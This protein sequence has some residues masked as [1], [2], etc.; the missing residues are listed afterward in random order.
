MESTMTRKHRGGG[1]LCVLDGSRAKTED[2]KDAT[3]HERRLDV[4]NATVFVGLR[5]IVHDAAIER[6][7][8]QG[9]VTIEV[10]KQSE[11]AAAAAV[12]RCLMPIKLRGAELKAMRRIMKLTLAELAKKL[13]ERTA[14]ETVSRWE[15]EAQPMGGYAEKL[16]R[17]LVCETLRERAPG[18]N[19]HASMIAQ[20]IVLDPW[21]IDPTYDVPPV[22]LWLLPLVEPCKGTIIEAWNERKAA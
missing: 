13:D 19:Y 7:D 8:E 1:V 4:Y 17:L 14:P 20:L 11:L 5:T 22:E 15:S 21:R 12:A 2:Q 6:T 16:L 3:T 9:E 18:I 10:P